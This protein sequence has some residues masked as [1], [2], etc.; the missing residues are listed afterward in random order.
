M[1]FLKIQQA[2]I[3]TFRKGGAGWKKGVEVKIFEKIIYW[4]I[5]SINM[6]T[7]KITN[8]NLS[9]PLPHFCAFLITCWSFE[10]S[11]GGIPYEKQVF[12]EFKYYING[13]NKTLWF[14]RHITLMISLQG[15]RSQTL[16][17]QCDTS[18]GDYITYGWYNFRF[19]SKW[20]FEEKVFFF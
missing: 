7:Q 18:N 12:F 5:H 17:L 14:V 11:K 10:N 1:I 19:F 20:K 9:F 13:W 8:T 4:Y 2:R 6:Y 15:A 16:E 3:Q